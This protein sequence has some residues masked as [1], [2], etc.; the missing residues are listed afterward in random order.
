MNYKSLFSLFVVVSMCFTTL[1]QTDYRN[2]QQVTAT[3]QR[4]ASQ[5]SQAKLTSLTKTNGGKD[6][7][8]LTLS[9]GNPESHPGI[10]V[11]GGVQGDHLLGTELALNMAESILTNH[12]EVL[13]K[14]TFYIF[15]NLSPD[16][17]AQYF[18]ATKFARQG[19]ATKTDDDRD[20]KVD[21]DA[22]EDLN[23]DGLITMMR[24]EDP[25]GDYRLLEE[26]NRILVKADPNKGERGNY[27]LYT[28]G[29]D[30][31]KDGVFNE[32]GLGGVYFN[33]NFTFNFPY[34]T[35]GSGEHP[36]SQVEHRALLD[37]L[38]TQ[39][40]LYAI[41]TFSDANNL[42]KPLKYNKG[43][44]SK[45]VVTSILKNDE[46]INQM[47]S[48][49]Y[50]E[51]VPNE[52]APSGAAQGGSAFEWSY[53]HFGRLAMSTPGWWPK[54][55][56]GDSINKAPE[57][58]KANFLAYAKAEGINNAFIPW[59][60]VQHPDFPNHKVEVGG[61][62]PFVMKNPPYA[63]VDSISNT[64]TDFILKVASMQPELQ[65]V[66]L[67]Q[68]SVGNNLT[69]ITVDLHN[70]GLLPTHT[71]MGDK[72][73]WLRKINVYLKTSGKQQ[74]ISGKSRQV[75]EKLDGDG[76]LTMSWLIQGSG[77]VTIEATVPQAGTATKTIN[78]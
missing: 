28:E 63:M 3:L 64:H 4:L 23:R 6:I 31:D 45:R 12:P 9:D 18:A 13:T 59:Q 27:K 46:A 10:A 70:N 37:F 26:D 41:L 50:N 57:N 11:M 48:E 8:M 29:I 22:F 42:S 32:D 49:A 55:F 68:E 72:S 36:I 16:A 69:R 75:I 66:N 5:N 19:N 58:E 73:R 1:A 60:E 54:K 52:N 51:F 38:Y 71:E 76:T 61:I 56:E 14:T 33:K 17:T 20:G 2:E 7:W 62:H 77:S 21:E 24:V 53:F 30:N 43:G 78:L 47:L 40:N 74:L 25:T 65:L 44:A 39:W 34:F 67:Q 15:P 35:K